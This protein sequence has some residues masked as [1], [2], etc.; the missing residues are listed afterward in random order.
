[1]P[2]RWNHVCASV[3]YTREGAERIIYADGKLNFQFT[4]AYL[5]E[6][7]WLKGHNFTFGGRFFQYSGVHLN[8]LVTDVQI[9]SRKLSAEEMIGYTTCTKVKKNSY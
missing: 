9:F 8:G 4:T 7:K 3:A 5:E 1:M 6:I 2:I